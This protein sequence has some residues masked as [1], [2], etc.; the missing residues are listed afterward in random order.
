M[1]INKMKDR[2]KKLQDDFNINKQEHKK[3]LIEL[4]ILVGTLVAVFKQSDDEITAFFTY[5]AIVS[6]A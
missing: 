5:F 4:R 1:C 3:E 6:I 2:F